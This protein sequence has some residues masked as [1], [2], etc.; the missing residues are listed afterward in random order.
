MPSTRKRQPE[1]YEIDPFVRE[2]SVVPK[3]APSA[4][5]ETDDDL[6]KIAAKHPAGTDSDRRRRWRAKIT[7]RVHIRGSVGTIDAFEDVGKTM[8]VSRDGILLCTSRSGYWVGQSLQVTFPYWTAPTAI[9]AA[10]KATVVRNLP[11]KG[12]RYAVAISFDAVNSHSASA[13]SSGQVKVL[14]VEPDTAIARAVR[15]LLENDGYKVAVVSNSDQA[16]DVLKTETPDVLLAEAELGNGGL[17]GR[18]LCRMIKRTHRLQHIP[19]ILLTSSALPSDYSAS[20]RAGA[21][22]CVPMPCE[23]ERLQKTVHLVAPPP[24]HRSP[25]DAAFNVASFVRTS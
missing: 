24:G 12:F 7:G 18:D 20:R 1:R 25:Y 10:R 17:T 23:P 4:G 19:V 16:L 6:Q 9:N 5:L 14:A 22:M 15:S 8:D 2:A 21:I 3:P 11:I 13:T